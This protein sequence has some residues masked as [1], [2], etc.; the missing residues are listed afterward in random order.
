FGGGGGGGGQGGGGGG[1][2]IFGEAGDDPE[3]RTQDE[4]AE[5]VIDIIKK[6]VN[7]YEGT[8]DGSDL[9]WQEEGG[10]NAR[11]SIDQFQGNL[12]ITQTPAAHRQIVG[13]LD[14]LREVRSLQ[15]N[16]ETRLITVATNWFE[17]VGVDLDLYFNTNS[18]MYND[19]L[20]QD[21]NMGI[22]GF[23]TPFSPTG[24]GAGQ[25]QNP[26][27]FGGIGQD[28]DFVT[29]TATGTAIGT[30]DPDSSDITYTQAGVYNPVGVRP[31]GTA[32][33]NGQTSNG[34]SPIGVTNNSLPLINTLAG[35][36]TSNSFANQM[37]ANPVMSTGFTYLDDIQVD[38]LVQASQADDRNS[39]LTAPRLTLFNG[40]RSWISVAIQ[41]AY[42]AGLTPVTGDSSGAFQPD[43]GT[44]YEGFV[45]D[46]QGVISADRRYVSMVV[47]FS[48]NELL[49]M[50]S[51][52]TTGAVGGG[53]GD[54]GGRSTSEFGGTI[55]LPEIL[56]TQIRT[57]ASVPDKG[58]LLLGGQ[59][60]V[61]EYDIEVG[62][63]VLSKMP[64][65]NRFFTNRMTAKH[66][67]NQLLL[68]RPE[69][70]I[71]GEAE[72]DLF[73][74]LGASMDSAQLGGF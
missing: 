3:R 35:L 52:S 30:G 41:Q 49:G 12:I 45:L 67:K 39:T 18:A 13:I 8:I 1:G 22:S 31:A 51:V 16:V 43:I 7:T 59:R 19:A 71:Q 20:G 64:F 6:H 58:T 34:W 54:G 11:G 55:Q 70:I 32:Y 44:L 37:L 4:I 50:T 29:N 73:P 26:I 17:Q 25:L 9:P 56:A 72:R 23:F 48:Q 21:P 74:N 61:E 5:E 2:S 47:V 38:L 60:V 14:Q 27:V 40:Q 10:T 68:I 33:G 69:I 28:D 42:V 36:G 57:A 65:V 15:L 62:V 66:E 63:P 46:I 24:S 53:T